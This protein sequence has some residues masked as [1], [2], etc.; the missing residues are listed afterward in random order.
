MRRTRK[1]LQT[2]LFELLQEK[3]LAQIQIKEIAKVAGLSRPAFY[4]QFETK[5]ALLFSHADEVLDSISKAVHE[6]AELG[7]QVDM[8][9]IT[10]AYFRQ[11]QK[12]K[13]LLRWIFQ[14]ENKD[15]VLKALHSQ[16]KEI[17]GVLDQFVPPLE[18]AQTYEAYLTSFVS[19]GMYML[20]KTWLDNDMRESP[21]QMASLTF[22]LL[23]N[24]FSPLRATHSENP[25]W[26]DG[27]LERLRSTNSADSPQ[28]QDEPN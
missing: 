13:R 8:L 17:K 20:I 19:G 11:W 18:V 24:G 7:N 25:D 9:T 4:K 6:E 2:A 21:E 16:I 5:E 27:A 15:L 12:H 14:V 1:L 26:L 22:M 3:P 10:T 28:V 23:Y